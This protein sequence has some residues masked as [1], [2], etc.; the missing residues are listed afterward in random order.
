MSDLATSLE[1]RQRERTQADGCDLYVR[2][3][4]LPPSSAARRARSLLRACLRCHITD[5]ELLNDLEAVVDELA[6]NAWQHACGPC[7]MRVAWHQGTPVLCEITDAGNAA[8][9]LTKRLRHAGE[10]PTDSTGTDIDAL[11][12]GG[13]GLAIVARLTSGHCGARQ[14]ELLSTGQP[15]TSVWFAI[16]ARPPASALSRPTHHRDQGGAMSLPGDLTGEDVA[17]EFPDWDVSEVTGGLWYARRRGS[18]PPVMASGEDPTDLRDEIRRKF[19]QTEQVHG[20]A[21]HEQGGHGV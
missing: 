4:C 1:Q 2:A 21:R 18:D 10:A 13:R 12:E 8:S 3:W 20:P 9:E 11:L 16:P 5:E 15:G 6:A 7:E 17:G 19:A 14:T